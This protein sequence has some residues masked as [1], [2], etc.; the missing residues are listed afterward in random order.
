MTPGP[1]GTWSLPVP[2]G[3]EGSYYKYRCAFNLSLIHI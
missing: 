3:W 1:Q 2:P